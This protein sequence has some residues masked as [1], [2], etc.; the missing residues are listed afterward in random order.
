MAVVVN[1]SQ[2]E[3]NNTC[4]GFMEKGEASIVVE[5]TMINELVVQRQGVEGTSRSNNAKN[6]GSNKIVKRQEY[7]SCQEHVYCN[8]NIN[9][10]N[11]QM[12]RS[13][14]LGEVHHKFGQVDQLLLKQ[15][16]FDDPISKS[17][18]PKRDIH[19]HVPYKQAFFVLTSLF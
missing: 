14:G 10:D 13:R 18:K 9:D 11:G 1:F 7:Y 5:D 2:L 16:Y 3:V 12:D 17:D 8:F 4:E 15:I 19:K 6:M